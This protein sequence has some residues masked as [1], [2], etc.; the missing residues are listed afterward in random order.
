MPRLTHGSVGLYA[1]GAITRS[2]R[3]FQTVLLIPNQPLACSAFARHYSRNLML[4]SSPPGTE[5]F[6]FPGFASHAY[7]FSIRYPCGWVAPFGHP[8]INACARLPVAFRSVP[9]PSSPPGAKASTECPSHT[10][11]PCPNPKIGATMH[12]N[13][14]QTRFSPLPDDPAGS[15]SSAHHR[16]VRIGVSATARA[17]L[18]PPDPINHSHNASEPSP[19]MTGAAI[20]R[21]THHPVRQAIERRAM[22]QALHA[23]CRVML[24][25]AIAPLPGPGTRIQRRTRT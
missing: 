13:H 24:T 8:R 25:H 14:P 22:T 12:R 7:G 2:G 10:R 5:M 21:R 19:P 15:S 23:D 4:M 1:Y 6:Q 17:V 20:P 18:D 9:R 11:S 16:I 3:P